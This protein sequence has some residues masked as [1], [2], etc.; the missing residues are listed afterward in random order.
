MFL[1]DLSIKRPVFILMQVAAVIVLG[2]IAY[3]RI[4]VDLMPDVQFPFMSITTVYPGAGA[5]EMESDVSKKIEEGMSSISG[6]KNIYST[7]A[8]GFSQVL[9]EFNLDVKIRD[10]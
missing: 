10:R 2:W 5:K 8:E 1:P 6:M 9:L 7:S 4:P 3:T